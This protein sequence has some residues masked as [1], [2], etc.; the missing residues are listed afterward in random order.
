MKIKFREYEYSEGDIL[1]KGG[2]ASVYRATKDGA[3]YALKIF[4]KVA[5]KEFGV[6]EKERIKRQLELLNHK[7]ETLIR[8][9]D[10]G[11]DEEKE[12]YFLVM[13]YLSWPSLEKSIE[14][15]PNDVIPGL[16]FQLA[17]AA[18]ELEEIGL[19]H[20][21]I[22]PANIHVSPDFKLL[23]L[24]DLGVMQPVEP[25]QEDVSEGRCVG[26]PRYAPPEFLLRKETRDLD[27]H[28]AITF[29]QIGGVLHDMLMKKP[30]FLDYSKPKAILYKA[31]EFI[32]PSIVVD[33]KM[34]Y[35]AALAES[36]LAKDPRHRLKNVTWNDFFE[37]SKNDVNGRIIEIGRRLSYMSELRLN[38]QNGNKFQAETI[39]PKY[40]FDVAEQVCE[41]VSKIL[42]NDA[43]FPFTLIYPTVKDTAKFELTMHCD[44]K[45]SADT[46]D[47]MG[48]LIVT[49][50]RETLDGTG[51]VLKVALG[52]IVQAEQGQLSARWLVNKAESL[53]C[54]ILDEWIAS[55]SHEISIVESL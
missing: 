6:G 18:K 34:D 45:R 29:Y 4:D 23:K 53:V 36:C 27:G 30:L 13:E 26:T 19:V 17:K 15:L 20:R 49:I 32:T 11:Y 41:A 25:N 3:E 54:D 55:S 31:V 44:L 14:K 38:S 48:I 21:D 8:I 39:N 2:S 42:R 47:P 33:K 35:W 46:L 24:L 52:D 5:L 7:I 1:G 22:K 28:R 37:Q 43:L 51:I 40:F 16:V 9:F 50:S 12:T 10:G